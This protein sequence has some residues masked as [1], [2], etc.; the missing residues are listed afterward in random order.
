MV[1]L[2]TTDVPL[3]YTWCKFSQDLSVIIERGISAPE[4][5][6]EVVYGIKVIDKRF[7]FQLMP[8]VKLTGENLYDIHMVTH[9]G[10]RTSGVSLS[11]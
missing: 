6:I 4:Y 10:I 7:I 3:H 8:T 9:T 2:I 1:P 11:N 5:G